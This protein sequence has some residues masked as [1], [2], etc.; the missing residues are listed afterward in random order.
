MSHTKEPRTSIITKLSIA[1]PAYNEGPTIHLILDKIRQVELID[2]IT[3]EVVVVNDASTDNTREAVERYAAAHPDFNLRFF[4]Q[5][6]NM[7]KGAA[8]HRAFAESTGEYIIVQDADLEYD[9]REYNRML[10]PGVE[11]E[12]DVVYG[13]R[14]MGGSRFSTLMF[15]GV[16][17]KTGFGRSSS[18]TFMPAATAGA[19]VAAS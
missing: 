11:G 15:L 13:S 4:D 7:G 18:R 3:K 9:P 8:L 16:P 2:G 10:K 12:A 6:K 1:I 19:V 14:F 5:P 17:T